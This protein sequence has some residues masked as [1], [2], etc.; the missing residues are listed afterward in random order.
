MLLKYFQ[1]A[2]KTHIKRIMILFTLAVFLPAALLGCVRKEPSQTT[3]E[4]PAQSYNSNDK[5]DNHELIPGEFS[6]ELE[7]IGDEYLEFRKYINPVHISG[8]LSTNWDHANEVEADRFSSFLHLNFHKL[9]VTF[10]NLN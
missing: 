1:A 3:D 7:T 10:A 2:R 8:I 6:K 5:T 9:V 4:A